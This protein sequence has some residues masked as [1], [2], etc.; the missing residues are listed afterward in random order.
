L[1]QKKLQLILVAILE[2]ALPLMALC[3]SGTR[4]AREQSATFLL[5][6]F[7]AR[8]IKGLKQL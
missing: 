4:L 6:A 7:K 8:E 1:I 3:A 2:K 5:K